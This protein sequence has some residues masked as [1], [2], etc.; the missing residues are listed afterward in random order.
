MRSS[1][2]CRYDAPMSDAAHEIRRLQSLRGRRDKDLSIAGI[3]DSV[4]EQAIRT[5]KRLGELIELWDELVPAP[6]AEATTLI[7]LR[8]GVL[9]VAADSSAVAYE[10]DRHL[11]EGLLAE[12]RGRYRGTLARVKVQLGETGQP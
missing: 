7:G 3:I 5:N 12:L 4:Q 8:G 10:L 11:R 6:I 9:R 1:E 2:L